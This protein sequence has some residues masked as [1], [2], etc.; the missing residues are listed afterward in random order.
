MFEFEIG[1]RSSERG[2]SARSGRLTTPHGVIETPVFM[3]VGTRAALRAMT[4]DQVV[5]TGAQIV[6]ANTYHL[7]LQPGISNSSWNAHAGGA[8]E[9][10]H[11]N[12]GGRRASWRRRLR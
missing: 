6:L 8:D 2:I 1:S 11:V 12:R 5:S 9:V 10:L 4:P 7:A 3:P